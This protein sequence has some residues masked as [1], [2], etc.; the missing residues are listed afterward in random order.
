MVTEIHRVPTDI[1]VTDPAND[2]LLQLTLSR[3]YYMML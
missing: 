2:F 3:Y 1:A